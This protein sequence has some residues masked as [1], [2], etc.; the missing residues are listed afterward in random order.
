VIRLVLLSALIGI[1][2]FVTFARD[3]AGL[4]AS[5]KVLFLVIT[6]SGCVAVLFPELVQDVA[7][8]LGVGRGTDLLLYVVTIMVLSMGLTMF[9]NKQRA[10]RREATL[11]QSLA[12]LQAQLDE[13]RDSRSSGSSA[14]GRAGIGDGS[15]PASPPQQR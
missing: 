14:E 9:V 5:R 6:M 1:G 7:E 8:A 10:E 11:V 12:I 15:G 2:A 3:T 13:M 4:R